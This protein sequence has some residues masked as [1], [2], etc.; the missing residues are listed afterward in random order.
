MDGSADAAELY[1]FGESGN[2]YKCALALTLTG[3]VWRARY[4]DFFNG[5][6]RSAEFRALNAMGEV[7]V[8]V[9]G[10]HVLTQSGGILLHV[11]GQSGKMSG[12]TPQDRDEVLRWI[13][14]DNHKLSSQIGTVRFLMNFLPAD[15]RPEGV[16]PFM[17][18]R[19]KAAYGVLDTHLAQRDWMVGDGP[20]I[21]DMSCCG[22][23]FYPEPF[24]FD[25][26]EWPHIDAWL[27]RIAALPG[28]KHPYELMPGNPSDRA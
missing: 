16:I 1:C 13:L 15:K 21:A 27:D 6:T 4:V 26:K 18:G 5:E 7:P 14:W 23:L 25:R 19:L 24:G 8:L 3:T 10:D 17:Q 20:T 2:A 28:W 9:E 11:A 12:A 22:Y